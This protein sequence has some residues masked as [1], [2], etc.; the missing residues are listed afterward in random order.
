MWHSA[1]LSTGEPK[2]AICYVRRPE[3]GN[4]NSSVESCSH[5]EQ[6]RSEGQVVSIPRCC[7]VL[8]RAN[9][10]QDQSLVT[11]RVFEQLGPIASEQGSLEL[12][13]RCFPG[14]LPCAVL[15]HAMPSAVVQ[16][17]RKAGGVLQSTAPTEPARSEGERQRN[18]HRCQSMKE[19]KEISLLFMQYGCFFIPP[20]LRCSHPLP[21]PGPCLARSTLVQRSE[22]SGPLLVC[23]NKRFPLL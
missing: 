7:F 5:M 23:G 18:R 6:R 3:E 11:D 10:V 13:P 2:C 12:C 21:S 15:Q 20:A 4:N 1:Q 8:L 22:K 19:M 14:C 16:L 17:L 9:G